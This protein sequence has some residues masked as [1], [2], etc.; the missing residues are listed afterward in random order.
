LYNGVRP[1]LEFLE[2]REFPSSLQ[3]ADLLAAPLT[4]S[5]ALT[6]FAVPEV[7][8]QA[9]IHQPSTTDP[10]AAVGTAG[11]HASL[12]TVPLGN[13]VVPAAGLQINLDL[14]NI[15]GGSGRGNAS[16]QHSPQIVNFHAVE[17]ENGYWTFEGVVVADCTYGL[18]VSF[19]GLP[20][21]Q[22]QTVDVNN[23]GTFSL[24]IQLQNG[25]YGDAT[26]Q[27]QG[28][29]QAHYWVPPSNGGK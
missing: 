28:S 18:M 4:G 11:D 22:G 3:P 6:S 29:L 15:R 2:R 19:G 20:S 14:P 24:M 8:P 27:T 25:E 10:V 13:P 9:P 12:M 5:L 7:V 21:L 1:L 26:A 23:D 17:G 16:E